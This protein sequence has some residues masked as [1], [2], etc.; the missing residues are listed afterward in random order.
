MT[1]GFGCVRCRGSGLRCRCS[2]AGPRP[3]L[4]VAAS[5]I[6][7]DAGR[8]GAARD[9]EFDAYL[10]CC[11]AC[12]GGFGLGGFGIGFSLGFGGGIGVFS[13]V[14]L[15]GAGQGI[16]GHGA[17]H[18]THCSASD[19]AH[20]A[21]ASAGRWS[22]CGSSR[23]WGRRSAGRCCRCG[24]CRALGSGR[25]GRG[26]GAGR[27][28]AHRCGACHG[29]FR[30]PQAFGLGNGRDGKGCDRD[31]QDRGG[32]TQGSRCHTDYFLWG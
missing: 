10:L 11:S 7:Q 23:R 31:G 17:H 14:T 8:K 20:H 25:S 13:L 16:A 4:C 15:E 18:R 12:A 1:S 26:C 22:R 27:C 28:F 9:W 19:G 29:L 30:P 24:G 21:G 3:P 6:R 32:C 5:A 2:G